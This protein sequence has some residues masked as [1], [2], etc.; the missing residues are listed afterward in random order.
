MLTEK[1]PEPAAGVQLQL[2]TYP[3]TPPFGLDGLTAAAGGCDSVAAYWAVS[4]ATTYA[5]PQ[6][7]SS[8][9]SW[10]WWRSTISLGPACSVEAQQDGPPTELVDRGTGGLVLARLA[11]PDLPARGVVMPSRFMN[12]VS[13]GCLSAARSGSRQAAPTGPPDWPPANEGAGRTAERRWSG[14]ALSRALIRPDLLDMWMCRCV[15]PP[16][17]TLRQEAVK[18]AFLLSV[19]LHRQL[20]LPSFPVCRDHHLPACA[21]TQGL[22]RRPVIE[23][24][25]K[26]VVQRSP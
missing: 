21:T 16:T 7:R 15:L 12:R 1:A 20:A 9:A 3:S 11:A 22:F 14:A 25:T 26:Q 8:P 23:R 24:L 19:Q 4:Q 6:T 17:R 13:C 18:G 5:I 2:P 10:R